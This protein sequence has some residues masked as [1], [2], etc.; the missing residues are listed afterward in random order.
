MMT[1]RRVVDEASVVEKLFQRCR[2]VG[3]RLNASK[4]SLRQKSVT[5]LGHVITQG[6]QPSPAKIEA[7]TRGDA[8]PY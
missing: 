1:G 6:L 5:F 8:K 7:I 4:M 2:E 3:I